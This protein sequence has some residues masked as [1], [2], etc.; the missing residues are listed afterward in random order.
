[1]EEPTTDPPLK[2]ATESS[3]IDLGPESRITNKTVTDCREARACL[4]LIIDNN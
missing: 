2:E 1:M 4:T 3:E